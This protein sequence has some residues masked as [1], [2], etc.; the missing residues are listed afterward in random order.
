MV[1]GNVEDLPAGSYT[2]NPERHL[3][4]SV[5]DGDQRDAVAGTAFADWGWLGTAAALLLLSADLDAANEHFTDQ[6]PQGERGQRY[7][8]LEAGHASQNVYLRTSAAGLGAVLVAGFN[9][10]HLLALEPGVVPPSH[11]PLALLG[12][13]HPVD[14]I[15]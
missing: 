4:M 3:L 5:A 15:T 10:D 6:P 8:W 11:H 12:I 13:G 1:A 9:D 2:Y 14:R 7:V